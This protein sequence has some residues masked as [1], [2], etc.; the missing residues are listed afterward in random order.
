MTSLVAPVCA[1]VAFAA[2]RLGLLGQNTLDARP[3]NGYQ[4]ESIRTTDLVLCEY[5]SYTVRDTRAVTQ[6]VAPHLV[7]RDG[8]HFSVL[9]TTVLQ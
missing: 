1:V 4:Y 9:P 5:V 7:L 6:R 8:W 3:K 2:A